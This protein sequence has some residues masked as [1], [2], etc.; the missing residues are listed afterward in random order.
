MRLFLVDGFRKK[1]STHPTQ[2]QMRLDFRRMGRGT[3]PIN[4]KPIYQIMRYFHTFVF[5]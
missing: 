1:R 5:D 3:K 2:K 4:I